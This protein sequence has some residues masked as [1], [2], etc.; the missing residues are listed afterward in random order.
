MKKVYNY[1]ALNPKASY[2]V[3][4]SKL[5]GSNSE[6]RVTL[7]EEY[8]TRISQ[9]VDVNLDHYKERRWLETY[10]SQLTDRLHIKAVLF[11]NGDCINDCHYPLEKYKELYGTWK[12]MSFLTDLNVQIKLSN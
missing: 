10:V 1:K 11:G 9:M 2:E 6:Y 8:D 3:W 5:I 7:V 12:G 4:C